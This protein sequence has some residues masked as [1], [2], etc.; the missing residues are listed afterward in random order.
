MVKTMWKSAIF[1]I[2]EQ[3][4]SEIIGRKST[5]KECVRLAHYLAEN[6]I[7]I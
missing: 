1:I 7:N 4:I 6:E 3:N 2:I 5:R